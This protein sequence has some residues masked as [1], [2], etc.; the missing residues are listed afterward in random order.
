MKEFK[1]LIYV[2]KN[3]N[4]LLNL[5]LLFIF[6]FLWCMKINEPL[7]HPEVLEDLQEGKKAIERHQWGASLSFSDA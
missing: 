2:L 6:Y 1:K 4:D 5:F 3:M 7:V